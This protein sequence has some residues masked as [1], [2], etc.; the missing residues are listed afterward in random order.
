M[1]INQRTPNKELAH[2]FLTAVDPSAEAFTFQTFDD[3][4]QRQSKDLAR[5]LHGSLDQ[6][7]EKLCSLSSD[8]AGVFVTIN[9][10]DLTGRK[11]ENVTK[12][13]ALWVDT[14]GA[15]QAPIIEHFKPHLVIESS[16]G[17]FHDYHL[18]KN[19]PLDQFRSAQKKLIE[20][21][22]TDKGIHDLPR[23]MRLPGFPHQKVNDAKELDGT[24]FMVR[25]VDD[26]SFFGPTDWSELE[27]II[28]GIPRSQAPEQF[29]EEPTYFPKSMDIDLNPEPSR[30]EVERI[31]NTIDPDV[32]YVDWI[33]VLMGLHSLSN[34]YLDL[35]EA[36]S[37]KGNKYVSGEVGSKWNSFSSN[38]GIGWGTV[39]RLAQDHGADLRAARSGIT[40]NIAK[41]QNNIEFNHDAIA[42]ALG[43]D[44]FDEDARF[45]ASWNKWC[46]W[47]GTRWCVD[48]QLLH[49]TR[50]R[51]FLRA[52]ADE[53]IQK[54]A[55]DAEFT[56]QKERSKIKNAATKTASWLRNKSAVSAIET[57]AR[58]NHA[59][60][61]TAE[62]FDCN[63]MLLG[64]PEGT[65]DLSTGKMSE[66]KRSDM[67]TKLTAC[68]PA[69][70]GS[71][72][73]LWLSFLEQIFNGDTELV[74]FMQRLVGYALT[75]RTT[76]HKLFF[77]YGTGR[78]GKSVFLNT[79]T[80]LYAD[81]AR[82]AASETFLNSRGDKHATG[83]AGL[84]GARLVVGSELPKGKTW[85]EAVIKDLTGGDRMTARFMRGDFFDFDPQLTLMIA[86]NN[87]PSFRG[88]DE[89]IRARVVM[90]P[91]T[92]TIPPEKRDL[93]LEEKLK[94]EWPSILR[95]AIDGAIDWQQHGLQVPKSVS[96]ASA[97]YLNDEDILRQF[98]DE[99]TAQ[100]QN[101]FE[102][103]HDLYLRFR[104]WSEQQGLLPWTQTTFQKELKTRGYMPH[105]RNS[106]RGFC[107]LK[108]K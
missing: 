104:F 12:I 65:V 61:A 27:K 56:E 31:L 30:E 43:Q 67:I 34:S 81:Y 54:A 33:N 19:C 8:G 90:I 50:I 64:T 45:V 74:T 76:E 21:F 58:S 73:T 4:Q 82:R 87:Q 35:A 83:L 13:R 29:I 53:T 99:E 84:Q 95:W 69:E 15:D 102:T 70:I 10:T 5:V 40:V 77:L 41:P 22:K 39:C 88:I 78:N 101:Y 16:P 1:S 94:A 51:A 55:A 62:Q 48:D 42:I 17:N 28:D 44:S 2:Q 79:L 7:W 89:A 46:F 93:N 60:V 72:P 71:E 63:H 103:T 23:V 91:F 38:G 75:G 52:L 18:V 26:T 6:H 96:D 9:E 49:M 107:G 59:S 57:L 37:A 20:V 14:D 108:L 11:T 24:P 105:R 100:E 80:N 106:G 66:A 32:E 85:D 36:W 47:D 98:L 3:N 92:V 25:I 97:E 86:G 68:S